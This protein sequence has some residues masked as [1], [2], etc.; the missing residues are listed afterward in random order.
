[1]VPASDI[2]DTDPEHNTETTSNRLLSA[3]L[4]AAGIMAGTCQQCQRTPWPQ[5]CLSLHRDASKAQVLKAPSGQVFSNPSCRGAANV[6]TH[7]GAGTPANLSPAPRARAMLPAHSPC[8][9]AHTQG[10]AA[11]DATP[12]KFP[13]LL[14]PQQIA[15]TFSIFHIFIG[16]PFPPNPHRLIRQRAAPQPML[17]H[18]TEKVRDMEA[19][20]S[21]LQRVVRAG[22]EHSSANTSCRPG[23]AELLLQGPWGSRVLHHTHPHSK[24]SGWCCKRSCPPRYSSSNKNLTAQQSTSCCSTEAR[25]AGRLQKWPWLLPQ[26][27]PGMLLR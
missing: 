16:C 1:M 24:H 22:Q 23:P 3:Q 15:L 25:A 17:S 19:E 21:P 4:S 13:E 27:A 26:K 18:D 6:P 9:Q 10:L 8:T 2:W 11:R 14:C 7:R 5:T 12:E 20:Q